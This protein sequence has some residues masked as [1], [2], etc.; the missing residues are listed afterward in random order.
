MSTEYEVRDE[1][2]LVVVHCSATPPRMDIGREQIRKWH[3]EERGFSDVGYHWIIRRNGTIE[4]GRPPWA[5][6]AHAR[7]HNHESLGVCL[8]GG[9]D[10]QGTPEFNFTRAQMEALQNLLTGLTIA[11][12]SVAVLGHRDLPEVHKACP[13][14]NV[15]AWWYPLA[16]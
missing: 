7:G 10:E 5:V 12:P 13:S 4:A 14:F 11:Y 2:S 6:G 9:T 16:S 1:T 3:V 15:R 8:V